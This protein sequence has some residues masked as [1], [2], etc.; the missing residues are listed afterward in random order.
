M[1]KQEILMNSGGGGKNK[2][3]RSFI[4]A[5]AL[6]ARQRRQSLPEQLQ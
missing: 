5:T 6:G 2:K 4:E 1:V 3:P